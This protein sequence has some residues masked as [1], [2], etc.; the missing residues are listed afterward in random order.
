VTTCIENPSTPLKTGMAEADASP[1]S[2]L[3]EQ[4]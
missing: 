1:K 2:A 3:Y 4:S